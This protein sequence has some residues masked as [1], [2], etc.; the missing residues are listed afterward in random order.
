L[1]AV[2]IGS[3]AVSIAVRKAGSVTPPED[4]KRAAPENRRRE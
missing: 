4:I 1:Q 3:K 2:E